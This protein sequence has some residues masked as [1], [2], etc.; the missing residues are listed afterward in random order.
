MFSLSTPSTNIE[1]RIHDHNKIGDHILKARLDGYLRRRDHNRN[2]SV[3]IS[4]TIN[5]TQVS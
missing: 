4:N 1:P 3:N 2:P 5:L